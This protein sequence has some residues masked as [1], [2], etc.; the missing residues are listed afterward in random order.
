MIAEGILLAPETTEMIVYAVIL[1]FGGEKALQMRR[2]RNSGE[3]MTSGKVLA[4]RVQAVEDS[5]KEVKEG[6]KD[7][8]A[9]RIAIAELREAVDSIK[10]SVKEIWT[11]LKDLRKAG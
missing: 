10:D 8:E 2:K 11:D 6:L 9:V 4:V 5:I 3:S 7:I 1:L